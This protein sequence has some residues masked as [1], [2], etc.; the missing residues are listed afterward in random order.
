MPL[1]VKTYENKKKRCGSKIFDSLIFKDSLLKH[2]HVPNLVILKLKR[3]LKKCK[4]K[5]GQV[6]NVL[7]Y[8]RY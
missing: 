5:G 8:S 4:K 1:Q 2:S 6:G 3:Y 7:L